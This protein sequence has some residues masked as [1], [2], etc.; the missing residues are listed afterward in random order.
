VLLPGGLFHFIRIRRPL[1]ARRAAAALL[2]GSGMLLLAETAALAASE[3]SLA[4]HDGPG[5]RWRSLAPPGTGKTGFTRLPP[6]QTG[7]TFSN[8]LSD[9]NV[10]ENRILE[11]GSGVALGDVDGDGWCDVYLCGLEGPNVLYRNLGGWR[12]E[13]VT[14]RAGVACADQFSTGAS[15]AD[16]DGDG[17]LDL[18]VNGCRAGTRLFFNDGTGRFTEASDSGLRRQGGST[19]SAL[20]DVDGDGD[21]D[22]YVVNYQTMTHKD[23]PPGL[24]VEVRLVNGKPVVTPADRFI[25]LG[26]RAGGVEI[27]ERG[28]P[29]LLYL[30]DGRG[31]FT[32]VP[33]TSGVF[34]DEDG[35]PLTEAPTDWGL[36]A[37][38]RDLNADGRPDLYVCNDFAFWP[39]R[40]WINQGQGRFRAI[41]R[42]ALR[43]MS[44]SAMAVDFADINRDGYDDFCVAD[45]LDREH[46]ARQ[47]HRPDPLRKGWN[48]PIT[49]PG[50]RPEV[51]RNT[52]CLNRGDGT[53]AE[54]AQL[55]GVH[56]SDW[57]WSVLF[58]DVDL[59]GYEDLLFATGH[60][61]D[62]LDADAL[63][64]VAQITD[65]PTPANKLRNWQLFPRLPTANLA[66]RN[67]HDLTFKEVSAEWGFD[68]VGV[69]QAAALADLDR[70]GDL[71]VV[72]NNLGSPAGVYRN[73]APAAR[74]AVRLRGCPPNTQGIGA[75]V[76]VQGGAV[77]SQSQEILCGGRYLSS[78]DPIRVFA[79]GSATNVLTVEVLWR[80]GRHSR[81]T[82]V[83]ANRLYE[84][85]EAAAPAAPP[86]PHAASP[87]NA[88]GP[89]PLFEDVSDLL[90]HTHVEAPFDDF[91]RQPLLSRRFSTLGPGVCWH[92]LDADGWEDLI[93]GGGRGGQLAVF[94]NTG[95]GRFTPRTDPV[96]SRPLAR[97]L[98][99]ILGLEATLLAGS[100]NYEDG[101]T[102][103]GWIRIYDFNRQR[104]GESILGQTASVGPLALA[105]VD[106]N[107]TLD[108]F[109]GGRAVPGRYPEP[110]P[111]ILFRSQ[112]GGLAPAQ[113][114]DDLGLVSGAVFSDLDGD[115]DVDLALACEWGPVRL[116]Q[117]E[118]GR[119][120][121]WDPPIAVNAPPDAA[122]PAPLVRQAS[123][124]SQLTG[125]WTGITTGD[126]DGDGRL[127]I[128][129]ANWG[130]NTKYQAYLAQPLYL[131]YG[132]L[133]EN[134][135]VQGVEAYF[136][137]ALNKI[138]PWADYDAMT[139]LLPFLVERFPTVRAY[140]EAGLAEILGERM[141]GFK[142]LE[143]VTLDSM[144][145]L[146]RG[147]H[148]D[149]RPLPIEAQFAPAFGLAVADAD[150]DGREDLF[151]SQNF[152]DV[153]LDTS[154][155]DA[156]RGLWLRGD[157][158]GGLSALTAQVSGVAIYGAQR[159][160]ALA[161][162]DADGRVD[163][164][165]AQN[166][167]ATKLY[168]N[169]GAAPG[170]RVRLAGPAGNPQGVGA[171]LR[172]RFGEAFGPARELH[173]G[174]GYWSQDGAV[175]VLGTPQA[176][177]QLEVRWPS[178]ALH[179]YA[180]APGA[181]EI[182]A[183]PDGRADLRP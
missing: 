104:S 95:Q 8:R 160:C 120:E 96:L 178:G 81:V 111:S 169:V 9:A 57:S 87:P 31:R 3:P 5:F 152:F 55:S 11:N 135:T 35:R 67:Q 166:G 86:D 4:W 177:T 52:L 78:D 133:A 131:Y 183:Y 33:W 12:F 116:F 127:D 60:N 98:T 94:R 72:V 93:L 139:A 97:D 34:L 26:Q 105:D 119:F 99:T 113:R 83:V 90:A 65:P 132:D 41:A 147:D 25:V 7:I 170:L 91:A 129:A 43:N 124:L 143:A 117:N 101:Q 176:P 23:H 38:F 62:V 30:N 173:A 56:A 138:V 108:L 84:I 134:G 175:Q 14:E 161:D 66:F 162:Y 153:D 151:L 156:G 80:S 180:L 79:A 128:V 61:H 28:E 59:D 71:D 40:V 22:L 171:R 75:R 1:L 46:A 121:P 150:G 42:F 6:E 164:A 136:E 126:F 174:A 49:D 44:L 154:R 27:T 29:D 167:G 168:R 69:S 159:G 70:D 118:R 16:V 53:Y 182:T 123:S 144:L 115:G 21:L 20:A 100:S 107:G 122:Q 64:T 103:G 110:A 114:W 48:L 73:D 54:I 10:A 19:T 45:M 2:A 36:A 15:F 172:L 47:R 51:Y 102:N 142:R 63:R 68:T 74:V 89:S 112:G 17:D 157:G 141:R 82:N 106:G 77:P 50:Y 76:T 18:L 140:S 181:R 155:Y 165:V 85:D 58:L 32:P 109:A 130:R 179:T 92:D 137:P 163:L 39:D 146:N 145:F 158:R 88:P 13:D 24:T 37:M 149:A 125:W 148:F